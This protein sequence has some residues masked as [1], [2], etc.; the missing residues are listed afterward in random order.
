MLQTCLQILRVF[1]LPGA[2]VTAVLRTVRDEGCPGLRLLERDGEYAV[3]IQGSAP[4]REMAKAYCEKWAARLR[5]AFGDALYAEGEVGLAEAALTALLQKRKLLV[6]VDEATGRLLGG[7]LQGLAHSEAAFDFGSQT[8]RHP[9]NAKRIV[10][11]PAL[12]QKFPGDPVQAA[13]GRAATALLAGQADCA[14]V[15]TPAGVGQPPF[16]LVCDRRGAV[17]T[18]LAPDLGEGAITNHLLDLVRRRVLGLAPAAGSIAFRPGHEHPLLLVS[19]V[20][21]ARRGD[22]A[23]FPAHKARPKN[24]PVQPEEDAAALDLAAATRTLGG[25]MDLGG[26][27]RRTGTITFEAPGGAPARRIRRAAPQPQPPAP[28]KA[29]PPAP[30]PAPEP[31]APAPAPQPEERRAPPHSL[32]DED[33]PDF[34]TLPRSAP[35]P[36]MQQ[37]A[38]RLYGRG[39]PLPG[40]RAEALR[41]RSLQ[42]I[43]RSERRSR[44][45]VLLILLLFLLILLA[46]GF[47]LWRYFR[48]SLGTPPEPRMYGTARF[49]AQAA[50]YLE[51]AQ[52]KQAGV[53]GYLAFPGQAGRLVYTAAE[54]DAAGPDA[55]ARAALGEP[56]WLGSAQPGHTVIDMKDGLGPFAALET[57]KENSGFTL[58]TAAQD[59]LRYK[60][61]GVYYADPAEPPATAFDPAAYGDL[62]AYGRYLAFV[63]GVRMRSLFDTGLQ[64]GLGAS[65]LTLAAPDDAGG[66]LCVTGRLVKGTESAQLNAAAIT[67]AEQPLLP[68]ARY[69]GTD[70]MPDV[71]A[72][73]AACLADY[74]ADR[75][76]LE[77][78]AGP[79]RTG[80]LDGLQ[81][82]EEDLQNLQSQAENVIAQADELM[83]KGLTDVVDGH[84][85][86]ES[87]LDQGAAGTLPEQQVDI[88]TLPAAPPAAPTEAPPQPTPPPQEPTPA[89]PDD[90]VVDDP[91][92]PGA[93]PG[94]DPGA[95]PTPEPPAEPTPEPPAEPPVTSAE[96]ETINVTMNGSAQTMD[97]VRC[98]AMVAQNELGAGAPAEA[99][100]AQCVATHC[101]ILSQGGYPA[102][103]GQ[104]PGE[105]ALAA[106]REVAHVLVTYNG[107][108]A[109]TPYFASASKGTASSADVWGGERA[110]LQPVDSPYDERFATNWHTNGATSGTARFARAQ[111]EERIKSRLGIDLAGVDPNQWFKILSANEYGWVSKMQIG[112]DG[113]QN[114]TCSGAWFRET[115]LARQSVTGGSLRS[116][117]FTFTYDAE[118]DCFIFDVYGYGHG[119]GMSQWGA[120]GCA[121]NGWRYDQILTHYFPGTTLATY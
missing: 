109:F 95:E 52:Q 58:Y 53:L 94:A 89:P 70:A 7:A 115:L 14:A 78:M 77:E 118:L 8:Y 108:V 55:P 32:L 5:A 31:P 75:S 74:A 57:L 15:Y 72:L 45:T 17:A 83:L 34:Y 112:P 18:A 47:A 96:G 121:R 26:S 93:E 44:R 23:R 35:Q 11:P 54:A 86:I 6:A 43:E 111:L 71:G 67:A 82:Q 33:V 25:E 21:Q 60:V 40:A 9:Q 27:A 56:C 85:V 46:G 66:L 64:T 4:T 107:K 41:N 84:S 110:W 68:A 10:V 24:L 100:K 19:Q 119:C 38:D 76:T 63:M 49:D 69:A 61:L 114:T 12:A 28:E 39:D 1:G 73:L 105:A 97:L 65:F 104:E 29:E 59:P 37:A 2:E 81:Q 62:S 79:G 16:V 51:N 116:Q 106:A 36:D 20:G 88:P 99:Y 22:T 117:C 3:C 91:A 113:G 120:V 48:G 98:L 42:L 30:A 90:P 13:A 102:V 101:W 87:D 80:I 103:L 50:A 92:D